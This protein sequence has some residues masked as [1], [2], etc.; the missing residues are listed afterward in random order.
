MRHRH[1]YMGYGV[2]G[3]VLANRFCDNQRFNSQHGFQHEWLGDCKLHGQHMG[4]A[5][6]HLYGCGEWHVWCG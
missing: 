2:F 3:I 6:R 5:F 1:T 4:H